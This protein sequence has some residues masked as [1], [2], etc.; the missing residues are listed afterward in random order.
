MFAPHPLKADGLDDLERLSDNLENILD[1]L[2]DDFD[3]HYEHS[4]YYPQLTADLDA[5]DSKN[6]RINRLSDSNRP[7]NLQYIRRDLTDMERLYQH[8]RNLV[9][10][11][12]KDSGRYSFRLFGD[13]RG[14]YSNLASASSAVNSMGRALDRA[15]QESSY[16]SSSTRNSHSYG[17][18][19]YDDDNRNSYRRNGYRGN[20]HSY[21]D[22]H[23]TSRPP[24][25]VHNDGPP[26]PEPIRKA[27][28]IHM[29]ILRAIFGKH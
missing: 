16:R 3:D 4:R 14:V 9:E 15:E 24:A 6:S 25:V 19:G 23:S 26:I 8:M 21:D 20:S 29:N 22:N 5:M 12:E 13:T 2:D 17:Y 1:D 27:H 7:S 11:I 18:N 10:M 28:E